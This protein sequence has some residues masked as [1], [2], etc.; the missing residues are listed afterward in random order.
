[1][2]ITDHLCDWIM[3]MMIHRRWVKVKKMGWPRMILILMLLIMLMIAAQ[4]A[5]ELVNICVSPGK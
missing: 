5:K 3:V 4:E 2:M 1:M